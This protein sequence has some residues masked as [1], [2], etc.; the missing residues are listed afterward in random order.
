MNDDYKG[1]YLDMKI[2]IVKYNGRYAIQL[3]KV[4]SDP[5]KVKRFLALAINNPFIP[6]RATFRDK[7]DAM[8]KLKEK[9]MLP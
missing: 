3:K 8:S 6:T 9:G 2:S 5:I 1:D 4:I 7:F